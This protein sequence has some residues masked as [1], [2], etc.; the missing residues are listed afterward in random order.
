MSSGAVFL[1]CGVSSQL[2]SE[3]CTAEDGRKI[4]IFYCRKRI[5]EK[6]LDMNKLT[7]S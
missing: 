1:A 6:D 3:L 7:K 5:G 2:L 4:G